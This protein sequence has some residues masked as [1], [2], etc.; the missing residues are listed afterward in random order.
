MKLFKRS[1]GTKETLFVT[2]DTT[3]DALSFK[4]HAQSLGLEGKLG[5]IPRSLS[6]DCGM[7]WEE[8]DRNEERLVEAIRSEGE[9]CHGPHRI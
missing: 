4:A 9:G 1:E 6:A 8:P 2:F 3:T 5:M 7:A